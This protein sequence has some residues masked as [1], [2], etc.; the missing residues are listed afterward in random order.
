MA[1]Q[2]RLEIR[3]LSK[4]F[5]DTVA[6][7][8]VSLHVGSGEVHALLGG[9]GSGKSTLIKILAGVHP[10]ESDGTIAVD[11]KQ[12]DSAHLTAAWSRA[13][14]LSFVHQDL[15]L[16]DVMT[17]AENLCAGEGYPRRRGRIDWRRLHRDAQ[18]TLDGLG[19]D[20]RADLGLAALRPAD[21][22]LVAIARALR[23]REQFHA[24]VLVLDEP[25]ARLPEPEVELLLT[26]L[27]RY[28]LEGQTILYVSHRLEEVF[29]LA[30]SVTVLR[31]GR[32]VASRPLAELGERELVELIAGRALAATW[33]SAGSGGSSGQHG[34]HGKHEQ[35]RPH[36]GEG[37]GT[38]LEL[39]ELSAGPLRD[40]SLSLSPGEVIG[41]AGLV[42]SGRTTLLEAIFGARPIAAGSVRLDGRPLEPHSIS[43]SIKA[44]LS[45]VPE[46]RTSQAAF[47]NLGIP[48]NL[49]ASDPRHYFRRRWFRHRLERSDAAATIARF[50]IRAPGARPPLSSLSG[51]NQQKVVLARW[52]QRTPR[53]LLLDE[54][55]Q[56]VDVGA[57]ADIYAHIRAAVASGAAAILASSDFDELLL[58]ADRILVLGAG[59]VVASAPAAAVDRHWLAERVYAVPEEAAA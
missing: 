13:A 58:L 51:G 47:L 21:R 5:G 42:G 19:I 26:A 25:T 16:F 41:V 40:V 36:G 18:A 35:E 1:D 53:L 38:L 8:A 27:R 43:A 28:A 56:G 29:A 3:H 22:T 34:R 14:G 46:D 49:S 45:Y 55:T 59:R 52:L 2:A 12:V 11:G 4:Q 57:R 33:Q 54:P 6:L 20:V 44:G 48:E 32:V 15:G 39:R 23:G 50:G 17:V 24:G 7:D 9:N 37:P 30:H 10:G 31:D